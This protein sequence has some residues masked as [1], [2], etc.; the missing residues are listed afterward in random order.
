[1]MPSQSNATL[2][3]TFTDVATNYNPGFVFGGAHQMSMDV[4]KFPVGNSART[5]IGVGTPNNITGARYMFG[6]GELQQPAS[7]TLW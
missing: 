2:Q 6:W 5:L 7:T 3:P 1:M 4:S